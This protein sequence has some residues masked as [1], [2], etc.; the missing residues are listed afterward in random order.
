LTYRGYV[1]KFG[2]KEFLR[3][4]ANVYDSVY[5]QKFTKPKQQ[6]LATTI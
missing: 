6:S 4:K 1:L 3:K 5:Y 2:E